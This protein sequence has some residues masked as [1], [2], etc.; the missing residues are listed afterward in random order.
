M[1]V[2]G[3]AVVAGFCTLMTV[4]F[5]L[6]GLAAGSRPEQPK[7]P[8][9]E[10]RGRAKSSVRP[11][12]R[13]DARWIVD[14]NR[15]RV[16]LAGVNWY[17]AEERDEVVGGL[18]YQPLDRIAACIAAM[19]FNSVRLPFSNALV[20]ERRALAEV[21]PELTSRF[22]P[23]NRKLLTRANGRSA[24]PID[25]YGKVVESLARHGLLV[26]L[27]NHMT[28]N[29]WCCAGADG[30]SLWFD[31][32][33][34][35][36]CAAGATSPCGPEGAFTEDDW[37]EDWRAMVR[38]FRSQP[39][40]VG[41]DLR[42]EVR[43]DAAV[44]PAVSAGWASGPPELDLHRAATAA[45]NAVLAEDRDLLVIVE[46]LSY[47]VDLSPAVGAPIDLA[48]RN[49]LVLSPHTYPWLWSSSASELPSTLTTSW[50][51]FLSSR[52][53]VPIWLGEFGT[54][55]TDPAQ[56]WLDAVL[57]T[58]ER[59]EVGWAWWPLNGTQSSGR[60]RTAGARETFGLLDAEWREPANPQLSARLR[61][62]ARND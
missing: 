20:R 24:R 25:V 32:F 34:G 43:P 35:E 45:G 10:G 52:Q 50:E 17:G 61:A 39:A 28:A 55:T 33:P 40:V 48:V 12:L 8:S 42:N 51:P 30:S 26:I 16:K 18:D 54:K 37:I 59:T 27:D 6:E 31:Q 15:R 47:A 41:V 4:S 2:P 29:D 49:R 23:E 14:A 36:H 11:P 58:L 53:A 46:G 5:G 56:A 19:G 38:R 13:T 44:Q 60:T 21:A 22:V 3:K 62:L 9:C 7:P 57:T 1:A